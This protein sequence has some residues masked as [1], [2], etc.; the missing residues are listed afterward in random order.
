[1]NSLAPGGGPISKGA[2]QPDD[3][4]LSHYRGILKARE[5]QFADTSMESTST[6][7]AAEP[8]LSNAGIQDRLAQTT[9]EWNQI[10]RE[11]LGDNPDLYGLVGQIVDKA[12]Q[13]LR[14]VR[15]NDVGQLRQTPQI[16]AN[17][18]SIVRIDG[19]RPSF[20]IRQGR[21]DTATSP[22]G[23]W[24]ASLNDN[25]DI[26]QQA[27]AC[28]GRI[29]LSQ[30]LAGFVGTGFLIHPNLILTNRHVLQAIA[31]EQPNGAWIFRSGAGI[32]FGQEFRGLTSVNPRTFSRVVFAGSRAIGSPLD[33]TKLDLALIEL[34][35]TSAE[36]IPAH[37]LGIDLAPDWPDSFP[38]IYTIGYP[39]NDPTVPPT[40]L[41]ELFRSTFGCKRL[42]PGLI[43]TLADTIVPT[44][45]RVGHDATTLGGNSGSLV[46]V[47]SRK[48]LAAGLHYA[49]QNEE[50]RV[51]SAHILGRVLDQTDG[52]SNKTL[53]EIL[54]SF[55]VSLEDRI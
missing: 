36:H 17:L 6:G 30:S 3:Q 38:T 32:D 19:S 34:T 18:E 25:P 29:N 46:L 33:H 21:V 26:L 40:L 5:S 37:L 8:D 1:M 31:S 39:A 7:G 10:I 52:R 50:P 54:T 4:L 44:P 53:R 41:E 45:F 42:A 12:D 14:V 43:M 47:A 9:I 28:V 2:P 24:G 23:D 51:N 48:H 11:Y 35:P 22:L 13:A 16:L 55:G 49:G 27:I 15:D 20:M